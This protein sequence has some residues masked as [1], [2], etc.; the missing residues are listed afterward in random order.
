MSVVLVPT[1]LQAMAH[2]N[3]Y[4]KV[5]ANYTALFALPMPL[6]VLV[7]ATVTA[8]NSTSS[9]SD[10][11]ADGDNAGELFTT[12]TVGFLF[13]GYFLENLIIATTISKALTFG[14]TRVIISLVAI[15]IWEWM[16]HLFTNLAGSN[17]S[18]F[19]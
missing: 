10:S 19:S 15:L 1:L 13:L 16:A 9:K 6:L 12:C 18:L 14:E 8:W 3:P 4:W 2:S 11:G 17:K 5:Y 7:A